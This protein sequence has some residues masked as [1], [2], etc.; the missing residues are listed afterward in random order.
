[1]LPD[2]LL[3]PRRGAYI[4]VSIELKDTSARAWPA[5]VLSIAAWPRLPAMDSELVPEARWPDRVSI[6]SFMMSMLPVR[7]SWRCAAVPDRSLCAVSKENRGWRRWD[8]SYIDEDL[9]DFGNGQLDGE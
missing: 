7:I 2:T 6:L 5:E 8:R 1:M 9:A 3:L 4:W